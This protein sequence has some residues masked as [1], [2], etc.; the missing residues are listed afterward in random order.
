MRRE[1]G[2]G[3]GILRCIFS[4]LVEA[5]VAALETTLLDAAVHLL[6]NVFFEVYIVEQILLTRR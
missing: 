6:I 3:V 5:R 2:G 1:E 4:N